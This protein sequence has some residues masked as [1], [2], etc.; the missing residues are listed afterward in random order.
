MHLS[1]YV[2]VKFGESPKE[3]KRLCMKRDVAMNPK[4]TVTKLSGDVLK[5]VRNAEN[6]YQSLS[7]GSK[8]R[9]DQYRKNLAVSRGEMKPLFDDKVMK[10]MYPYLLNRD[11][12][13]A[14]RDY[15]NNLKDDDGYLFSRDLRIYGSISDAMMRFADKD[16]TSFRWNRNYNKALE[17]LIKEFSGLKLRP[18]K[19]VTDDDV[20]RAL[21]KVTTHSGFS[22]IITGFREKR[23][24]VE[25]S[26][27]RLERRLNAIKNG[28][29]IATTPIL[30]G[31]R[32]QA[33]GEYD[34]EGLPTGRCKHKTR[35]VSMYDIDDIVDE[36]QF[37]N[38]FIKAITCKQW[39]AG[40]KDDSSIS[41]IIHGYSAK[42]RKFMSID[43][44]SFD[45]TISSWLI[46]DCFKVIEAS[47]RLDS[48][49]REDLRQICQRF[50]HKDFILNEGIMHSD[51]G[52]PS[53]SM[54]TQII[55]TLVN[56]LV[57]STYFIS[58]QAEFDMIA[59]GDDNAIFCSEDKSIE[60]LASYIQKNFGL[61]IKV[62][63]KSNEGNSRKQDV[64]FLSRFWTNYGPW[65]H[66]HE[67]I[68]RML[69]PERRRD[70][71]QVV[72]PEMVIWGYILTYRRGMEQLMD[73]G[74]F[75]FEHPLS[76][77]LVR[78]NVDSRYIPG[79]LAYSREYLSAA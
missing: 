32:T 69:F 47:F 3:R 35:V 22:Y 10:A 12:F 59:M 36:L 17:A 55:D 64:K 66:P 26:A 44:S 65:R 52:V 5:H 13:D 7:A 33:S 42:H 1:L 16:F 20:L 53:G 25:G 30:I 37:A 51:K 78:E 27:L 19:Y 18:E 43:Y 70:Y 60:Q 40:G 54:F 68:S 15:L 48:N 28:A 41:S 79:S 31:F 74:R 77:R 56:R 58:M 63:A 2:E 76:Q 67:L 23:A 38:P 9:L 71:D 11:D 45:Q 21:P 50:I 8:N 46:E 29:T 57:V 49:Q 62:D 34:D 75:M 24:N 73:I 39:Y 14:Q 72:T 61:I 6:L 4:R